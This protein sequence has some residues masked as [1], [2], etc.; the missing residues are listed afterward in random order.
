MAQ[1]S[2]VLETGENPGQALLPEAFS[3]LLELGWELR[4]MGWC[5]AASPGA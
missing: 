3:A 2:L 4:A 1:E 5:V